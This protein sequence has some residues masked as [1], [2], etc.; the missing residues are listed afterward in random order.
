MALSYVLEPAVSGF[1]FENSTRN[2]VLE[3]GSEEGK[4]K[5]P[6]PMKTGTT[7]AG[8]VYKD[9]VVLGADT[10]ATSDEV[11]ADKMCAKIHYIAPLTYIVV[12]QERLQTQRRRQIC[13]HQTSTIFSITAAGTDS[14][15]LLTYYKTCS[16]GVCR[17]CIVITQTLHAHVVSGMILGLILI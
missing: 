4:I 6:K 13:C 16:S 15:W 1:N 3:N 17:L 5:A 14:S 7:I 10:R 11:V 9:G 2:I 12:E 8:V